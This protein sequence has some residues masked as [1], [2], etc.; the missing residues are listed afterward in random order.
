MMRLCGTV[1]LRA[2]YTRELKGI[3]K[4]TPKKEWRRTSFSYT[5]AVWT[6]IDGAINNICIGTWDT[7]VNSFV[8]TI[9][10]EVIKRYK[11]TKAETHGVQSSTWIDQELLT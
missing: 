7:A 9:T 3:K 10:G 5:L 6:N 8:K 4:F 1:F 2:I 11:T